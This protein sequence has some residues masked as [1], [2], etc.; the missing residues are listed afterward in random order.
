MSF[1]CSR[2]A[3]L[4]TRIRIGEFEGIGFASFFVSGGASAPAPDLYPHFNIT[5][6]AVAAAGRAPRGAPRRGPGE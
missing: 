5:P 4:V 1:N 6:D 3:R 2:P